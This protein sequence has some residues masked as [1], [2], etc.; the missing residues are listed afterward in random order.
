M[1]NETTRPHVTFEQALKAA[2][3]R[4]LAEAAGMHWE[5]ATPDTKE[6]LEAAIETMVL[7]RFVG[8]ELRKRAMFSQAVPFHHVL[9]KASMG[10]GDDDADIDIRNYA[11]CL[12]GVARDRR[13]LSALT[14]GG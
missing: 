2:D 4:Q 13:D 7:A 9:C 14:G 12:I 1:N 11:E 10:L 5:A 8:G 6:T 3:R